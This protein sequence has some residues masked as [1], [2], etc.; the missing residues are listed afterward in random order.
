MGRTVLGK[1]DARIHGYADILRSTKI[2]QPPTQE[3][4]RTIRKHD[5]SARIRSVN[6]N[7]IAE[8]AILGPGEKL[9]SGDGN[10][11]FAVIGDTDGDENYY[12]R[13][14]VDGVNSTQ[15]V[16]EELSVS[17]RAYAFRSGFLW[18]RRD[19]CLRPY[20]LVWWS[21]EKSR[22]A[23]LLEEVDS[24]RRLDL[25]SVTNNQAILVS[26]G[27]DTARHWL[28]FSQDD[29]APSCRSLT[30][31]GSN[32]DMILVNR[33]LIVLDRGNGFV[34]DHDSKRILAKSPCEFSAEYLQTSGEVILVFGR[35]NGRQA[36]WFPNRGPLAVWTAPPAGTILPSFDS[37]G[38][39]L[40]F[41]SS[42]P[43]HRPQVI[44]AG[45]EKQLQ[46]ESPG[47]ISTKHL[48]VTSKDGMTIPITLFLPSSTHELPLV[49]HVYGAYGISLEGPFD[50]F[51]NDFLSRGVAV[52]F[53]HIRGGGELGPQWHRDA[54]GRHRYR[55]VDD[56]LACLAG[57]RNH[58]FI[59]E[60]RIVVT[61]ASAGGLTAATACLRQPTWV[62]GLHLVHP[63]IDPLSAL[64]NSA[65][66]LAST[67]RYEYGDPRHDP[68]IRELL[69]KL[70]PMA[71]IEQ[72]ELRSCPLPRAWIR[73]SE[74]DARV[75]NESINRFCL[76]YRDVSISNS[77]GHVIQRMT[78]GGH[79]SGIS[80]ETALEENALAHAWVLD[81][82]Q[83]PCKA[84]NSRGEDLLN[85][86]G[87]C[88][89]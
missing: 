6:G 63:F 52:A 36:V 85:A 58:P 4:S 46:D 16:Y 12:I 76:L 15:L 17:P 10:S 19:R 88:N 86:E 26:R 43:I 40:M 2:F 23:I 83:V 39:K 49:V 5:Q 65:A 8:T 61:A 22:P 81:V 30:Q 73:I 44:A 45:N 87:L 77:P 7:E 48:T 21:R 25:R 41:L 70:S 13:I 34:W 3:S 37:V 9:I 59:N 68:E 28:I 1:I 55:T 64:E 11:M 54:V 33:N 20:Q 42:S 69:R 18:I 47:G 57:L 60:E 66:N 14:Y 24:S 71:I 27:M 75:D 78:P 29:T 89:E 56:F 72:L 84:N 31:Y 35:S 62:R 38:K 32:A 82:L 74:R 51:T 79:L 80:L 53:C 50:P 67:D